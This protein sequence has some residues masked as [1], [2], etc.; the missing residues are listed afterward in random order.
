MKSAIIINLDYEGHRPDSC[1][2]FWE[3]VE[4]RMEKA[5]FQKHRRIFVTTLDWETACRQAKAVVAS[6]ENDLAG[7]DIAIFDIIREF[8]CFEYEQMND[9]LS[10]LNNQPEVSFL[11]TGTFRA[12][13]ADHSS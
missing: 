12:Y 3:E 2:R 5:G 13:V 8:Y 7:D 11:D 1:Q 6:I 10:P 4:R 9:L